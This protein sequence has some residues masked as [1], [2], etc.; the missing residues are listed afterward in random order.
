M[1]FY[2]ML[3]FSVRL[4]DAGYGFAER[5]H[6]RLHLRAAPELEPYS[7]Y[8]EVYVHTAQVD[9]LHAEWRTLGLLPVRSVITDELIAEVKRRADA[10]EPVGLI[11]EQVE[12]KPWGIRE[13]SIRDLDNNQQRFGR[14]SSG[15]APEF[16][17]STA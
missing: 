16:T 3:G 7:S 17:R 15:A 6:L 11:S 1:Q 5:E 9:D 12:D 10:G 14:P 13:F 2:A 8:S 4:Y